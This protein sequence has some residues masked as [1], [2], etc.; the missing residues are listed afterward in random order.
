[1][2]Q[3]IIDISYLMKNSIPVF[4]GDEKTEIVQINSVEKDGFLAMQLSTGM[5]AG[6]H[7]DAPSHLIKN[8]QMMGD[9]SLDQFIGEGVLLDV[10]G[11]SVIQYKPA[12]EEKIKKYS[13]VI[14]YTGFCDLYVDGKRY[15]A[16]YPVIA[17]ELCKLFIRKQCK[18]VGLDSPS[19]D[20]KPYTQHK[21]LLQNN[22]FVLENL[23]NLAELVRYQ[24]FTLFA[25]P[26]KIEAEAS[27]TRAFAIVSAP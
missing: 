19:P 18:I 14:L 21:A 6:T 27:L 1:M 7:I 3:K 20:K 13:C 26:L 2:K 5:H 12:Y 25:V 10:R 24:Q 8:E 9:Y 16:D 22:I 4:P 23:T 15:F 17:P 11:E